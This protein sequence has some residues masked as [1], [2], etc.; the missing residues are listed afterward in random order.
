M[1]GEFL[2]MPPDPHRC[3]LPWRE[4]GAMH[5][6]KEGARWQC[7]C[8]KRWIYLPITWDRGWVPLRWWHRWTRPMKEE[9]DD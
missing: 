4:R 5:H 7:G 9:T 3:A 1:S 2:Y 8:G 6:D